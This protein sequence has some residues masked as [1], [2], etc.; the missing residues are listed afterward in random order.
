VLVLLLLGRG[1]ES[2]K[3]QPLPMADL[4]AE[5]RR[6]VI[7]RLSE[8]S[9]WLIADLERWIAP[10]EEILDVLVRLSNERASYHWIYER[11]HKREA[12]PDL[13][14]ASTT[15][16]IVPPDFT[17]D[18]LAALT[19]TIERKEYSSKQ[20]ELEASLLHTFPRTLDENT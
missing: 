1:E 18:F 5:L 17:R 19:P 9:D 14:P 3:R 2:Y 8:R 15:I 6:Y 20:G 4:A 12:P 11:A 10:G 16:G 13:T 7:S